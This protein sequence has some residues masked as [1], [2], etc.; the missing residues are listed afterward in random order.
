M[1]ETISCRG[2]CDFTWFPVGPGPLSVVVAADVDWYQVMDDKVLGGCKS[3]D[4][5]V[6]PLSDTTSNGT[7]LISDFGSTAIEESPMLATS[8]IEIYMHHND[9]SKRAQ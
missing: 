5:R 4:G 6:G 8:T 7:S 2:R 3:E 9:L 1:D